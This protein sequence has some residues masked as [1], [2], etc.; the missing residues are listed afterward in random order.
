MRFFAQKAT[1]KLCLPAPE[2][3]SV[4]FSIDVIEKGGKS[5]PFNFQISANQVFALIDSLKHAHQTLKN[6]G[7]DTGDGQII[8]PP[9]PYDYYRDLVEGDENGSS[10]EVVD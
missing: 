8:F 3:K 4:H 10:P 1:M 7:I 9:M 5:V 6:A 2:N